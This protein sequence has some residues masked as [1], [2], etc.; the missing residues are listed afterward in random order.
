MFRSFTAAVV[1]AL[2]AGAAGAVSV[3]NGDFETTSP[4]VGETNGQRLDSLATPP[5]ANWDV[6]DSIP[7][8]TTLSGNGIEVQTNAT[9]GSIDAHSG[10]HYI[11]LDSHPDDGFS[12]SKMGQ[13]LGKLSAGKYDLSFYYSPRTGNLG[14]MGIEFG[15][16]GGASLMDTISTGTVGVWSQMVR[17]F[18]VTDSSADTTV[19]FK[20]VGQA[21]TL[22]GLVDT[23]S[24]APAPVPV[25][26]AALLL[27][28]GLAALGLV[29]RRRPAA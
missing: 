2:A 3:V 27:G 11:E 9:L 14:S 12:N 20:A 17:S 15:V 21:D 16:F 13:N 22:G 19:Y 23:V 28:S 6:F 1:I 7:G 4:V 24:V 8:W 5:H 29:R 18:F 26:A 10:W 25:P